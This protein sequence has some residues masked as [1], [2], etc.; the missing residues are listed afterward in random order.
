MRCRMATIEDVPMLAAMNDR[1]I[2]DEGHR[3]RMSQQELEARMEAFLRGEY[4]AAVF[5]IEGGQLGY[6]LYNS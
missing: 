1:L 4:S 3:N 5:E 2:Q 6:A